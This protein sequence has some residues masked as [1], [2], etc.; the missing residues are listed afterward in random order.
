[1]KPSIADGSAKPVQVHSLLHVNLN[2]VD[3]AAAASFYADVLGLSPGMKT[4]RVPADGRAL[5]VEGTPVTEAWFLYDHRGPRAAPA[6]E[7][8]EWE[9]PAT[10]GEHPGE[11]HHIGVSSLGYAVPS[12]EQARQLAEAHGRPWSELPR[13]PVRGR[14]GTVAR[15]IDLD[16]V[17]VELMQRDEDA[18]VFSHLRVNCSDL[19]SSMNWYERLGFAPE[20]VARSVAAD[21][22][23]LSYASLV[24]D[25]DQS[26]S[27]ELTQWE[28]PGACGQP[29]SPAYHR[30][31]YRIALGVDDVQA[32]YRVLALAEPGLPAPEFVELP[33]TRLGGVVVLFL[34]DPDG[35]VVELVGRPRS[36]MTAR[37]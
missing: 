31:L 37:R 17:P 5:G 7:V 29:S 2:T 4:A 18:P 26:F 21:G 22:T 30:G 35:V 20:V 32:A 15:M 12:L 25:G 13:W 33:G 24:T 1:V 6:I 11:P 16:G 28:E 8:L 14:V 19:D 23:V 3:V 10:V 27:L 34:R 36:A 9:S